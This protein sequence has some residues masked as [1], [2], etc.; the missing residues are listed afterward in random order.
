MADIK[1]VIQS[2]I[3][4]GEPDEK[5]QGVIS[6]YKEQ[7][8]NKPEEVKEEPTQKDVAVQE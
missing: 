1:T 4:A 6:A 7:Q 3:D 8:A 2:M 5:I